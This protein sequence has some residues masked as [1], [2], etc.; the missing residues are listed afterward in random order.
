[1]SA[2]RGAGTTAQNVLIAHEF[3]VVLAQCAG[4]SAVA[5]IRRVSATRPF[6]NIPKHLVKKLTF[7]CFVHWDSGWTAATG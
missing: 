5:G 4:S 3:A 7:L 6:P 1:M 2:G